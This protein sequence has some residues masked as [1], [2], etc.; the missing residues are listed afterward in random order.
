MYKRFPW[1]LDELYK[2]KLISNEQF[3]SVKAWKSLGIF[4][5]HHEILFLLY[6]SVLLFTTG[7]GIA[8][9]D[10]IDSIGH[11][12]ILATILLM[13]VASFYFAFR[14]FPGYS[15]LEAK[16]ESPVYDYL[17]L[18]GTLLSCIFI[19]YLQVQYEVFGSSFSI[20]ALGCAMVAF[21]AAYYFDNKSALSIG[22]TALAAFIGITVTPKAVIENSVYTDPAQTYFG[23]LLAAALISW[24]QYSEKITLKRHFSFLFLTFAL[25]LIGICC[26]K[27]MFEEVWAIYI[28]INAAATYF[29][30]RKSYELKAVSMFV[31]TLVYAYICGNI[32]LGKMTEFLGLFEIM[33]IITLAVPIYF[34]LSILMFIKLIKQFNRETGE[35]EE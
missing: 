30:Y 3:S 1:R 11:M 16:F 31:F 9:Y 13:T 27:G 20:S 18:L 24:V 5:L 21:A 22:I 32:F 14:H 25:H 19:T 12:A 10:N 8:I 17:V 28:I 29:F 2:R 26:I 34:V 33:T 35:S 15:K 7:V 23:I 6:L 4:S